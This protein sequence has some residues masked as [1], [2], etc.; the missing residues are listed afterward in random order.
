MSSL[1][2]RFYTD[3]TWPFQLARYVSI[4]G[5]V[6]CLDLGSFAFFLRLHW[7]LIGVITASW[8]LAVVTHF[9]LNKYVNFR[10]HDR[11]VHHQAVTYGIVA[12]TVWLTT[13]AIV[14]GAVALNVP[15]L[16]GKVIAIA[17]NLPLGFFGHRYLT[18]GRG[19]TATVQHFLERKPPQ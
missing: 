17:C 19:I 13:T 10:A 18:F 3:R 11:P 8:A 12:I 15:P 5:F 6:T 14:K 1:P 4:G 9:S 16:L 2:Q 7:P